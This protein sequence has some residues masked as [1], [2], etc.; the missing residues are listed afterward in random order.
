M[1]C[2]ENVYMLFKKEGI[3]LTPQR[4]IIIK[5][6]EGNQAHPTATQIY[7]RVK[8]KV[9]ELTLATVY[10]TLE[11]L[12]K[13]QEL[14]KF[15][16]TP[17]VSRYDPNTHSHGHLVCSQCNKVWDIAAPRIIT[18]SRRKDTENF[19]IK[20][21]WVTFYGTCGSCRGNHEN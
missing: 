5:T 10:N 12:N 16:L 15:E 6:L 2:A 9:P 11:M 4:R 3:K 1:E 8:K 19:R 18:P 7:K 21:Q 20:S 13:L 17:G 14:M